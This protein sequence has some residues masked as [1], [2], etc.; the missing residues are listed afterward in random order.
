MHHTIALPSGD[1]QCRAQ[2]F[3]VNVVA[4]RDTHHRSQTSE[5]VDRFAILG[6][7]TKKRSFSEDPVSC[8]RAAEP[9]AAP[10]LTRDDHIYALIHQTLASSFH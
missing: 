6:E 8:S 7:D 4:V 5:S 10:Q 9:E 1:L 3:M 2:I